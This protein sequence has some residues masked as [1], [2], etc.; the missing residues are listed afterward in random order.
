MREDGRLSLI[1]RDFTATTFIVDL[2][3]TLLLWHKKIGHGYP[4]VAI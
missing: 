3:K 1:T 4:L 2:Q